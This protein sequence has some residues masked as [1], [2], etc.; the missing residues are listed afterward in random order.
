M[1]L[2]ISYNLCPEGCGGGGFILKDIISG[3]FNYVEQNGYLKILIRCVWGKGGLGGG[4][5]A[6]QSLS[7]IRK[8]TSPFNSRSNE[9]FLIFL[10]QQMAISKFLSHAFWEN[11]KC[12]EGYPPSD[13]SESEKCPY[14]L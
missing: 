8:G 5:I 4:L 3:L 12:V 7:T 1:P 6:L 9:L 11:M 13:H 14:K 10:R 2:G